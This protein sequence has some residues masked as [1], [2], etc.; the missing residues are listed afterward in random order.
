MGAQNQLRLEV[1]RAAR[2]CSEDDH[3]NIMEAVN[4]TEVLRKEQRGAYRDA[5]RYGGHGSEAAAKALLVGRMLDESAI[6][7]IDTLTATLAAMKD[8]VVQA[9]ALA[10]QQK[11]PDATAIGAGVAEQVVGGATGATELLDGGVFGVSPEDLPSK[12]TSSR[13][14]RPPVDST[15]W[16]SEAW[17]DMVAR[18]NKMKIQ[19]LRD[20][21]PLDSPELHLIMRTLALGEQKD[22]ARLVELDILNGDADAVSPTGVD[23]VQRYAPYGKRTRWKIIG[24]I[25]GLIQA[26]LRY[27]L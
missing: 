14:S 25:Y 18:V 20:L 21:E 1:L 9:K 4:R 13:V 6:K 10:Q 12:R 24:A 19:G 22:V 26:S 16:R 2:D 27:F 23:H 5:M 15:S 8:E 3:R 17:K 7:M 11:Q